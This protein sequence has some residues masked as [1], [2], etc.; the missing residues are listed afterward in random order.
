MVTP[1]AL[2]RCIRGVHL[3]ELSA[4]FFRFAGQVREKGRPRGILNA[5]G[6]TMSMHHAVDLQVFHADD[7]ETVYD[8]P[9]LLMR[10][11]IPSERDPFMHTS[12]HLAML[13]VLRCPFRKLGVFALDTSQSLLFLAEK[14]GILNFMS[15]RQRSECLESYINTHLGS[16]FWEALGLTLRREG[17]VPFARPAPT[18]RTRF[19]LAL[20][21][22]VRDHLD[23]ANLGKCHTIIK[24]EIEPTLR[25]GETIVAVMA[26]KAGITRS[27]SGFAA[28]QERFE[29]QINANGDI[30]QHLRMD[31]FQ[32]GPFLFQHSQR[33]NLMI[34]REELSFLLVGCFAFLKKMVVEPTTLIKG[35]I[36]LVNL[37]LRGKD[38]VLK[39]FMHAL[40]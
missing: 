39:H 1:A 8:L 14:A 40:I 23:T 3:Y 26:T 10:K 15:I 35:V 24:G 33:I 22:T 18:N 32:R 12:Y 16:D 38:T 2:L 28:S 34:A 31:L 21:G 19:H 25:E 27:F 11:V 17:H 7:A 29:G 13:P 6:Q 9:T 37:F 36:Q 4:S 5:L 30:L 20:D